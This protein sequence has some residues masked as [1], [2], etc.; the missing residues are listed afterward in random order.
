[1]PNRCQ[2]DWNNGNS[3]CACASVLLAWNPYSLAEGN[4]LRSGNG[5][6]DWLNLQPSL[7]ISFVF[8]F[9]GQEKCIYLS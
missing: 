1:M 3:S 2:R 4:N 6:W 9:L 7:S 5:N 8:F